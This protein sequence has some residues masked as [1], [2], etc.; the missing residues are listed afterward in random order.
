MVPPKD[1]FTLH[2]TFFIH[3]RNGYESLFIHNKKKWEM[4]SLI[5]DITMACKLSCWRSF[6]PR[7]NPTLAP[8]LCL[9]PSSTHLVFKPKMK[10]IGFS[11]T[12]ESLGSHLSFLHHHLNI[13]IHV[14]FEV[15]SL[16]IQQPWIQKPKNHNHPLIFLWKQNATLFW[17]R[18]GGI[19]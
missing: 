13:M 9:Q 11:T 12:F 19:S 4:E 5:C 8:W 18:W 3:T 1:A 15:R 6:Y 10:K 16:H 2:L 7:P 17:F 14:E